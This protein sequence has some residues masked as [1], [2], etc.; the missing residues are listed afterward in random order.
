VIGRK[1]DEEENYGFLT[2]SIVGPLNPGS[3]LLLSIFED[4]KEFTDFMS[5]ADYETATEFG[6]S[7]VYKHAMF[8]IPGAEDISN[9]LEA[10]HNIE[11]RR[12]YDAIMRVI[13][14]DM[15]RWSEVERSR[16]EMMVKHG[17]FGNVKM[18]TEEKEWVDRLIDNNF[19][20]RLWKAT[21]GEDD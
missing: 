12:N 11:G 10:S 15:A 7:V 20:P 14:E 6:L 13:K 18:K 2:S 21:F 4:A 1:Q 8:F 3:K 5:N 16:Y 9:L 19:L 17:I